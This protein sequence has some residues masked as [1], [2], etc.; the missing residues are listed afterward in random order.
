MTALDD[1][2]PSMTQSERLSTEALCNALARAVYRLTDSL[3]DDD[4]Y[5]SW[6][7]DPPSLS[8]LVEQKCLALDDLCQVFSEEVFASTGQLIAKRGRLQ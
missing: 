4:E 7:A 1:I 6:C 2:V 5:E 8:K 3:I